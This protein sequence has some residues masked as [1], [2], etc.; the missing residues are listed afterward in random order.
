MA[1]QRGR[2]R[3]YRGHAC[4]A[5]RQQS[6]GYDECCDRQVRTERLAQLTGSPTARGDLA[7]PVTCLDTPEVRA[8]PRPRL[9]PCGSTRH[10]KYAG[11][12]P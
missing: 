4:T 5:L 2:A 8:T 11:G 10:T 7:R 9:A 1:V 12:R 6:I 3:L